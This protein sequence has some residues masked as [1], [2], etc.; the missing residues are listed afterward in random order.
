MVPDRPVG[1]VVGDIMQNLNALAR[2][3]ARLAVAEASDKLA[4]RAKAAG[5]GV[6]FA[7]A[8]AVFGMMALAGLL[9]AAAA[10]LSLVVAG[11][12]AILIVA[13]ASALAGWLGITIGARQVRRA[14]TPVPHSPHARADAK[15]LR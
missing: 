6:G 1:E 2:A 3:E 11:W 4:G 10:A 5:R 15:E 12:L 7:T 14:L 13:G 8:G 9:A